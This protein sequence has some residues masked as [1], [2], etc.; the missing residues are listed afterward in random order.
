MRVA[1]AE[2]AALIVIGMTARGTISELMFGSTQRELGHHAVR[3]IVAVPTSWR[4]DPA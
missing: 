3:P 2:Q 4:G 1:K